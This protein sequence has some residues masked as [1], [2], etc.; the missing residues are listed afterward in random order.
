MNKRVY[1]T[2]KQSNHAVILMKRWLFSL[3]LFLMLTVVRWVYSLS[4]VNKFYCA[5]HRMLLRIRLPC[6][7]TGLLLILWFLF[8]DAR[9]EAVPFVTHN[10]RLC[11]CIDTFVLFWGLKADY[12]HFGM[13]HRANLLLW[14]F[15]ENKPPVSCITAFYYHARYYHSNNTTGCTIHCLKAFK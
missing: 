12:F 8:A 5:A 11:N 9:L 2:V 15:L 14:S 6:H 3:L 4:L 13:L 1:Y 7:I 10:C